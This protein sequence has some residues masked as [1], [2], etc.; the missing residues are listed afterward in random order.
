MLIIR[1]S[2]V[3]LVTVAMGAGCG[4]TPGSMRMENDLERPVELMQCRSNACDDGFYGDVSGVMQPG[5]SFKANV[6]TS[7]VPN[8]WLVRELDGTR[9]GCLPLVMPE[10]TEGVVVRVS[11]YVPCRDA[12]DEETLWPPQGGG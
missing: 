12:Y 3:V 10:P 1:G 8:P 7:G 5:G 2:L 9:L 4:S 6:S 11:Q